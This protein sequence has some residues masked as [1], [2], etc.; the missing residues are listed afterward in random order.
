[1]KLSASIWNWISWN[2]TNFQLFYSW[3][4]FWRQKV[5]VSKFAKVA[6]K[7]GASS[8]NFQWRFWLE[9]EQFQADRRKSSQ[10][11]NI[12]T[13]LTKTF[14]DNIWLNLLKPSLEALS[15]I[16]AK[17]AAL[18][19]WAGKFSRQIDAGLSRAFSNSSVCS[20]FFWQETE[21]SKGNQNSYSTGTE[22][23]TEA[24]SHSRHWISDWWVYIVS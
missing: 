18:H 24:K 16:V 14:F 20:K 6:P 22:H 11:T 13:L 17:G 23:D 9:E 1:M 8:P 15:F 12:Q 21:N 19:S 2:L 10:M 5:V 4:K 7:D 3:K